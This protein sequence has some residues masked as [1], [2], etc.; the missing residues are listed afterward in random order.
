MPEIIRDPDLMQK[1]VIAMHREDKRVC[2]VPTMGALHAGHRALIREGRAL[3]DILIV[4][5]FVN[6]TQFAPNEDLDHYP[7]TFDTDRQMC[8]E[9]R[10]DFIFFPTATAMY[11]LGYATWVELEDLTDELCGRTRPGHF[12]GVSTVCTK[13]FLIT[14]AD[15]AVFGWKDAQQQLIIRRMVRDLN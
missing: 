15:V 10:V 7:R 12:R 3:A 2:V 4:T 11:P 8:D 13:L 5:I 14:Q 6:P 1:R 9:E